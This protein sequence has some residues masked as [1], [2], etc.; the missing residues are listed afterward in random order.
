[1][2]TSGT[3]E[4]NLRVF[5]LTLLVLQQ[6]SIDFFKFF[7]YNKI[8]THFIISPSVGSQPSNS[9]YNQTIASSLQPPI[10]KS[11]HVAK[12]GHPC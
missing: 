7:Y 10:S 9:K 1:M 11:L 2:G 4:E 6:Y 12:E 8:N 5:F 3:V